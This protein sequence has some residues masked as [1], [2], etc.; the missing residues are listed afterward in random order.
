MNKMHITVI[1]VCM[2]TVIFLLQK[3]R[4]PNSDLRNMFSVQGQ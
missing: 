2:Q 1:F 3:H 4:V